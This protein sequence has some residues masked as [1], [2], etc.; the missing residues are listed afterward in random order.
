MSFPPYITGLSVVWANNDDYSEKLPA[1]L[2]GWSYLQYAGH[3]MAAAHVLMT[4]SHWT[5]S[6]AIQYLPLYT[7]RL[8]RRLQCLD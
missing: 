7:C 2:N 1:W 8:V 4:A 5:V 3:G 6:G